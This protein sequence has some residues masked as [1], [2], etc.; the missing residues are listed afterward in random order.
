VQRSNRNSDFTAAA[1]GKEVA[2]K[3]KLIRWSAVQDVLCEK[4][5]EAT[6]HSGVDVPL[7]G[8]EE[9]SGDFGVA[10]PESIPRTK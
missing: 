10:D 2:K 8:V 7:A 3:S 4:T 1:F 5:V 6:G 9:I